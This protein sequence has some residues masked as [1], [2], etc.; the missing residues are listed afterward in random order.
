MFKCLMN[1]HLKAAM[2]QDLLRI[3][4]D[5]GLIEDERDNSLAQLLNITTQDKH[6]YGFSYP[7]LEAV[8]YRDELHC[9]LKVMLQ[10]LLTIHFFAR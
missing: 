9:Q 4:Q 2:A 3:M 5:R 8:K 7:V 1:H 6:E 10:I